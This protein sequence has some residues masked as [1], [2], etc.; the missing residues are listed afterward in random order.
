MFY[1][2]SNNRHLHRLQC[3]REE[4]VNQHCERK[5][6]INVNPDQFG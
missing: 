5:D 4:Q 6:L 3:S 1:G 2:G